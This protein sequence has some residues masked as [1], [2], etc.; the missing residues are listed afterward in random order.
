MILI[1]QWYVNYIWLN[2]KGSQ[3]DPVNILVWIIVGGIAGWLASLVMKTNR[4]QGLVE[5]IIIGVVG[6]LLGGFLLDV[7]NVGGAVTGLNITSIIVAFIGAVI[8]IAILRAVR[9]S[10]V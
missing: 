2:R 5:D 1:N 4:S 6:G 3:M 10:R 9:G 7:L 8:L